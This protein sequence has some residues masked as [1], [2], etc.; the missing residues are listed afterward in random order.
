MSIQNH[1]P[2]LLIVDDDPADIDLA[3]EILEDSKISL[4][5][6]SVRNGIEALDF[7]RCSTPYETAAHPDL[8]LL[9]LNMPKMDGREVLIE[10][11]KDPALCHTPV[12]VLTTSDDNIDICKSYQS[13]ANCYMTKPVGI[14]EYSDFVQKL[15]SFWFNMI[16]LPRECHY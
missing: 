16:Q 5:V 8:I 11:R 10:I 1:R 7:L 4:N 6:Q 14:P 15:E 13:G 2:N 12:I 3:L 9:D